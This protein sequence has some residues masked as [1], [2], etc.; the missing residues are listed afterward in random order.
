MELYDESLEED[1]RKRDDRLSVNI[2]A[3]EVLGRED[4]KISA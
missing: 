4:R 3:G 1:K 2:T